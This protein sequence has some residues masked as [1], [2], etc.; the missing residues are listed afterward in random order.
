MTGAP[1]SEEGRRRPTKYDSSTHTRWSSR[2]WTRSLPSSRALCS[3]VRTNDCSGLGSWEGPAGTPSVGP[4]ARKGCARVERDLKALA[5]LPAAARAQIEGPY[6]QNLLLAM[7]HA[8]EH[9]LR[10]LEGKDGNPLNEV[11][12]L[13]N[14][15][16]LHTGRLQIEKL[17]GWPN[18][19]VSGLT[20]P[21][22]KSILGLRPGQEVVL[23]EE[24]FR[25]LAKGFFREL[26]RRFT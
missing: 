24:A 5:K 20:L 1:L 12:V 9:R 26:E 4:C 11:R 3:W 19:A 18:S 10:T 6:L 14:S 16:L 13:C 21:P 7:N 17:P 15:I 8:F 23:T 22:E 25:K 2:P